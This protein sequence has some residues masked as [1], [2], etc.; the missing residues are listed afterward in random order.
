MLIELE[1]VAK[2]YNRGAA[3]E[4]RALAGIDL[5][6]AAGEAVCLKGPSG[7]G[8]STLL[9]I[10]GCV[11]PPTSGRAA[12][13][14]KQLARLPDRFLTLHRRRTIGFIFQRFNLLPAL[15]VLAN[16]TLPL[17]PLGVSPVEQ[18][19]RGRRLLE[20]LGI[21]HRENFPAGRISGGELQRVAIA[22]ALINEPPLIL[23]DEPTA[24]LDTRLSHEFMAIMA[25]LKAEGKTIVITSHD[26]LV[27]EDKVVDR[28]L[29]VIDG[30]IVA[31]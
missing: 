18:R 12:I 23:A 26:P 24:H 9:A 8:K 11:M 7:S 15:T 21:E 27:A 6:V 3:N 17:L 14:G 1:K 29:E 10:I 2:I 5:R 30:Q 13:A 25:E 19:R 4:V 31:A 20:R 16:V 28:V 22:R